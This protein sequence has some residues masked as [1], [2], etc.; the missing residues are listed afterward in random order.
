M[1]GFDLQFTSDGV[2]RGRML[3]HRKVNMQSPAVVRGAKIFNLLPEHIR[4]MNTQ[5]IEIFKNHLD[6]F[7]SRIPDQPTVAG[8]GREA[9]SNSLLH[10]VPLFYQQTF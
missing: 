3:L 10:Q 6:V 7:L 2:R 5:H 9:E 8:Q 4:T 1:S